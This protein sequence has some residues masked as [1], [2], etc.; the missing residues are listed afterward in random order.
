MSVAIRA[1]RPQ[2]ADAI[3]AIYRPYVTDTA[4]TFELLPPDAAEF[5]CRIAITTATHP[6]LVA[7]DAGAILG[8][9]HAGAYR[10]RAAYRWTAEVGIYLAAR[11]RGRGIGALLYTALLDALE[12]RGFVC[13]IAAMTAGNPASTAL[14]QRLGFRE[15]GVQR[16]IGFKHGAW[17]DVVFWQRDLAPRTGTPG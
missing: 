12:H 6:W 13:A 17:H 1:V 3:A 16:G 4:I 8:Y 11:A 2:D 10:A 5:E 9:A 14:H 15:A 7:E